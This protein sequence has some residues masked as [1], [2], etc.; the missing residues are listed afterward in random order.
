MKVYSRGYFGERIKFMKHAVS[1]SIGSSKRDKTVEI[2]LL[3]EKVRLER[4]GT[5]GDMKKAAQLY[6]EMDG[7]VDAFG[8]GGAALGLLVAD[9]WYPFYSV[10]PLVKD[11]RI[12]PVV[13][14]TG[15]KSTLEATIGEVLKTQ[16]GDKIK[17][18]NALVTTAVD[19]WGLA[20]AFLD[21][22]Y[23]VVFGDFFFS[24]GLPIPIRK[25]STIKLMAK[26]L[27]P[28]MSRLPFEWLY[29]VGESQEHRTPKMAGYF[30]RADVI[31]GDC[32]YITKYMPDQLPG[33]VIVT[34]TTTLEDVA[35]FRNAGV[36]YLVTTT[37]VYDGRS[38][39]TNMMEAA[40]IAAAGRK[41][42][43]DYANPGNYYSEMAEFIKK[44]NLTPQ[45]Q[46]L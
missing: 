33:K 10:L 6:K 18:K 14:G 39:G 34:N 15:L 22:D 40:I 12:T 29:P 3:G 9:H 17:G 30:Q 2:T 5:D 24:L 4:I 35:L 20:K 38:F 8:V 26:L 23:Q 32:H 45:V 31:A 28:L 44:I 16:L 42:A 36:S 11:V 7:K 19:R 43:V 27:I 25:E 13:D 46:A 37:P 1:I 21:S 41:Q